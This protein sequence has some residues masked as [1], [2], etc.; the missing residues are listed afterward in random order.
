MNIRIIAAAVALMAL[1]VPTR[2]A[3]AASSICA[4]NPCA[5]SE[6]GPFMVGI[7]KSCGN[8]GTCSLVDIEH[9]FD[10]V[11][12]YVLSIVGALVFLM[13]V[14]GG[15]YFLLSGMPGMEKYREKGKSALKTSTIGL[16]IIFSSYALIYTLFAVLSGNDISQ[17]VKSYVSCGPGTVNQGASCGLNSTCTADGLCKSLCE[18]G[19][20]TVV[21]SFTTDWVQCIDVNAQ[22]SGEHLTQMG[23]TAN[24]CP[25]GTDIQC[26]EFFYQ[27]E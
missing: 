11:A 3:L 19:H 22:L 4:N 27:Y 9:V 20:P 26:C 25:G 24:L 17:G 21:T 18:Q 7:S 6:V 12:S 8:E 1:V 14:I 13:Y 16:I 15:F 23:C 2:M 5:S 10:N